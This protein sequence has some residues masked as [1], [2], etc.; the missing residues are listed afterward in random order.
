M[1]E[2]LAL[3]SELVA[4]AVDDSELDGVLDSEDLES[5]DSPDLPS[6]FREERDPLA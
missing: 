1:S 2:E 6:P 5:D 3:V 4:P